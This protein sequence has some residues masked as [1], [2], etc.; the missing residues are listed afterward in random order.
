MFPSKI[1]IKMIAFD[2]ITSLDHLRVQIKLGNI[3][4]VYHYYPNQPYKTTLFALKLEFGTLNSVYI[5]LV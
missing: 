5:Y 1:L 2:A 3:Q 4:T